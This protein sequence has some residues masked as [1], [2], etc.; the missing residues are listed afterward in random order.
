MPRIPYPTLT[1]EQRKQLEAN[2]INL[3]RMMFHI[4]KNILFGMSRMGRALLW[5]SEFDEKL[6]ELIILRVGALSKSAYEEHQHRAVGK[7]VGLTNEQI[8]AALAPVV[9]APLTEREQAV[10]RFAE[11]VILH[12][13]PSDAAL[14]EARK[15]LADREIFEMLVLI[16]NYMMIA[17]IIATARLEIDAPGVIVKNPKAPQG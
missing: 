10:L 16:G 12:V 9:G 11:D 1:E 15:Y 5:E 3:G 8:E 6:R 13:D 4:P 7:R 17:R 14:S 2:P